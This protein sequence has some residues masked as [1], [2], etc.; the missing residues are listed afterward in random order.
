M[1]IGRLKDDIDHNG[2]QEFYLPRCRFSS[3]GS[4]GRRPAPFIEDPCGYEG[5]RPLP[6]HNLMQRLRFLSA[7]AC[8]SSCPYVYEHP[9]EHFPCEPPASRLVNTLAGAFLYAHSQADT[10]DGERYNADLHVAALSNRRHPEAGN[11]SRKR[12]TPISLTMARII[13]SSRYS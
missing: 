9:A 5:S 3:R 8:F 4:M 1:V 6:L 10:S 2:A 7:F 12:P 11:S 13:C